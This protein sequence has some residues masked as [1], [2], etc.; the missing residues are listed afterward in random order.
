MKK[1]NKKRNVGL[2][3][4]LLTKFISRNIIDDKKQVARKALKIIENRFN[5]NTELY[6]EFRLFNAIYNST[7]SSTAVA[8]GVLTEAKNAVRSLDE[9]KLRKEKSLLIRDINHKL[10]DANFYHQ[11]ISNYK[12]FASIQTLMNEWKLNTNA[13]L[14]NVIRLEKV[15]VEHLTDANKELIKEIK[16]DDKKSDALVFNILSEKINNKYSNTLSI[17]QKNIIRNY[18]IYHDDRQALSVYLAEIKSRT[19]SSL[20]KYS[21]EIKN[22]ILL[23]KLDEVQTRI[24]QLDIESVDDKQIIKFLTVSKLKDEIIRGD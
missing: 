4:E 17:E 1:H 13:D 5:N 18:A 21:S 23:S 10:G 11:K 19:L 8:V 14:S 16:V 9:S 15:I 7:V 3:Y 2:I 20:K 6:K 24:N 12:T 22:D